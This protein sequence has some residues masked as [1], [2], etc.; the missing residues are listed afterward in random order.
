MAGMVNL[1]MVRSGSER[2]GVVGQAGRCKAW[3]ERARTGMAGTAGRVRK[4]VVRSGL[5]LYGRHGSVWSDVDWSGEVG[6]AG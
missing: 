6:Q 3:W 1:G 5:A 2:L 4:C